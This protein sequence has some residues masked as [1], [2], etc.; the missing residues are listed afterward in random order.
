M[1]ENPRNRGVNF[2][3]DRG[4]LLPNVKKSNSAQF[5]SQCSLKIV[6]C[7]FSILLYA[8]MTRPDASVPAG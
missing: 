8:R 6:S 2:P 7:Q 5:L 1:I 4:V 3:S